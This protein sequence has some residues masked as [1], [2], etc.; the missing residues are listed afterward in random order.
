MNSLNKRWKKYLR[1][2]YAPPKPQ[3][4]ER[5][6]RQFCFRVPHISMRTFLLQ[7]CSYIS[8][9]AWGIS[10]AVFA[11]VCFFGRTAGKECVWMVSAILPFLV[12]V[13]MC[14]C[15]RSMTYGMAELELTA[16]FSLKSVI[17]A[18][19][20]I[21]GLG[22]LALLCVIIPV[23]AAGGESGIIRTGVYLTVP[24]L[25]TGTADLHVLRRLHN[26]EAVYICMGL[27]VCVSGLVLA[28]GILDILYEKEFL[29]LWV[30]AAVVLS[31]LLVNEFVHTIKQ[32]EEYV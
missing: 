6:L 9:G 1:E 25:L 8:A 23:C 19:I 27:S 5:F 7:Q 11:A 15:M 26:K 29:W 12:C 3:G 20:L 22:N 30:S 16:R 14:E 10:A 32:T 18:R 4:K 21:L 24:Y 2:A 17:T 28:G 31:M 13:T